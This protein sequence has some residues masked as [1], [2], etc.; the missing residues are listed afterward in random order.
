MTA[1]NYQEIL[2]KNKLVL[3]QFND[4]K[5]VKLVPVNLNAN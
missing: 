5:W 3:V 1:D 2:N 4:R